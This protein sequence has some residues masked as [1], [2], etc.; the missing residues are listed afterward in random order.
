MLSS[1]FGPDGRLV[2]TLG[3]A[4]VQVNDIPAPLFYSTLG[5]LGIQIPYEVAGQTSVTIEVQVGERTSVEGTV[6]VEDF[7]PGIF[8]LSQDGRGVAAVLHEDGV[9]PV[10]AE[11]PARAG[12]I[13]VLF[14]TGLGAVTPPLATGEP[15]TGNQ[16]V[17][18]AL[19]TIDDLPAEVLFSGAAP[20]FVA[21]YQINFRI[22]PNT[23]PGTEVPLVLSIGGVTSNT[24]TIA[25]Q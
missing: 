16:T 21:L 18:L 9:T 22:P 14:G 5:Q 17:T 7:A 20:G 19:V 13:V 4:S 11:S 6:P 10:T 12:E 2:T 3:G 24:V 8:T 23:R 25:V 15:S 1:S